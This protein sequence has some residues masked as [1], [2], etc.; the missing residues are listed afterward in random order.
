MDQALASSSPE[1]RLQFLDYWRVIKTRKVIVLLVFLLAGLT[2]FTVSLSLPKKYLATVRIKVETEKPTVDVFAQS[3]ASGYDPYFLQTQYQIIQ[4]QKIL[5]PVIESFKLQETWG[6]PIDI[7]MRRLK[8]QLSVRRYPD[9]SLIEIGV[10]DH[11]GHLAADIANKIAEVFESDRL[12]VKRQ[13]T[14]KGIDKLREEVTQQEERVRVVQ[15]KIER[16]RKEL[17]VPVVGNVKMS[18][19]TMQHLET[20]LSDARNAAIT[21][22]AR[23]NAVKKLT[24]LQLRNAIS[25]LITDPTTQSLS[26]KLTDTETSLET[27][28]EDF[29]PE[30]P[31]VLA[32]IAQRDK[33]QDQLNEH[34]EGIKKGIEL[35][36][37]VAKA[38][39]DDLQQ[40]YDDAKNASY[41]L[42][43]EKFLPFRNAQREEDLEMKL[44]EVVKSRLQQATIEMELPR[45]PVEV[46]DYAQVPLP[47]AYVSP[48]I[49]SNTILGCVG[50]LLLG[51]ALAFFIEFLDTSIK[52]I[53]DVEKYFG[54]P[55]LGVVGQQA[56][57][58]HR[59][60][61]SM[62]HLE[63]YRMMRTN[64]EFA[65]P[66]GALTSLCV[67][68]AG[69]GEGKSFTIINLAF[70]YAQH[71]AR[72]LI[73][74]SDL[75]RPAMHEDLRI[76]NT[77]G[78]AD[79][80][81]GQKTVQ[82]IIQTTEIPNVSAIAGGAG[83]TA[84][85]ALPLLT[86]RRMADLI[87]QVGRQFDVVLY[88][89]PPI[90]GVSDAAIMAR[91]V[92]FSLFVIQHRRYPRNM[93]RRAVQVVQNAGGKL[94]GIV[95]NNVQLGHDETYYYYHDEVEHY[96]PTPARATQPAGA[97]KPSDSDEI[98]LSG[99]Y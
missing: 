13:Q 38:R 82:E 97:A 71:G 35:E 28:K 53:E 58:L 15:E 79:Y 85:D 96:Q 91:E 20:E 36:Y 48:T 83:G 18:D 54:L 32:T 12:E 31:T 8:G 56:G 75:R 78:L 19:V 90:L 5:Y 23:L 88:D 77:I 66:T 22:E 99:K 98:N 62:A 73:V 46:I 44:E 26:Q 52:K 45:S 7:A 65:K 17:G 30:H 41:E 40:R 64:I 94:L 80:L 25:V 72:V 68:S 2:A 92:G 9:T 61:V 27:L 37:V 6:L 55:V 57:L 95:V 34:L 87:E 76:S 4:S 47:Q 59:G 11:D 86:S 24:P 3:Q 84:K 81:S 51:V 69:A 93:A 63:A 60:S 1:S 50:G 74:D 39:V 67:L 16:L 43:S 49:V 42:E 10:T 29:G 14:Q 33:L 89:T 70:V 21:S